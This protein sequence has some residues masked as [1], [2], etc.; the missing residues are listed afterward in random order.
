MTQNVEN[1]HYN[2]QIHTT[3][4]IRILM[5]NSFFKE[6]SITTRRKEVTF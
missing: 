5:F 3:E 6:S 4:A 1:I 2:R